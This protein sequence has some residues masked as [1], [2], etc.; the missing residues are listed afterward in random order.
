MVEEW[1]VGVGGWREAEEGREG[2]GV[3]DG[4][5]ARNDK[6]GGGGWIEGEE[7]K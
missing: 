4:S 1:G 6:G 7:C 5:G 3:S 2:R